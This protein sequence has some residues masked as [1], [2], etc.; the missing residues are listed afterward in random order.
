[1]PSLNTD[2]IPLLDDADIAV[3]FVDRHMRI[4]RFTVHVARIPN[5]IWCEVGRPLAHVFANLL[6]CDQLAMAVQSV[7]EHSAAPNV[8]LHNPSG[9][10]LEARIRSVRRGQTV[11]EGAAITLV[12]VTAIKRLEQVLRDSEA[13][14]R[15]MVDWSLEA[16]NIVR[17]GKFVYL[18]P[19]AVQLYGATTAHELLGQ[20]TRDRI[21]P[22]DRQMAQIRMHQL[23]KLQVNAPIAEMKF[24]RLDDTV[25]HA[26]AQATWIDYEGMPAVHVAWRDI[27]ERK[28]SEEVQ[29]ESEI[30]MQVADEVLHLAFHDVLTKLPNRRVLVD[31][32]NQTRITSKRSGCYAALLLLDLDNFKPLNDTHGHA[33]GDLLLIEVARRLTASVR[34]TDTVVRFGGDEF[35]VLLGVLSQD[36]SESAAQ[37][38]LV[39]GEIAGVLKQPYELTVTSELQALTQI[40]HVCS[41]S[42]GVAL[43]LQDDASLDDMLKW[44]DAAMYR[45]KKA[46]KNQIQFHEPTV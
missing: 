28:R 42:I 33:A 38:A 40:T 23:T 10:W 18:N 44:A 9:A 3:L 34:E 13:R 41:A 1:L 26:Q 37:A 31:R 35:V 14:Y 15:A 24:L 20:P 29:R 27:T 7:L 30:R 8:S 25:I 19:T 21:H 12:D 45:A 43:F 6:G 22:D 17:D 11:T 2:L 4:T 39:A 32:V 36:A 16:I 46:G 5:L